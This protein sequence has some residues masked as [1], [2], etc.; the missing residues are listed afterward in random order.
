MNA[1]AETRPSQEPQPEF[2]SLQVRLARRFYLDLAPSGRKPLVVVC[3]GCEHC[4]A[5]YAVR[6]ASFP[7]FS[8]E[9]VASGKGLLDLAGQRVELLPGMVFS[10]GP[11]IPHEITSDRTDPP[12]K[13]FIDFAGTQAAPLLRKYAFAPGTITRVPPGE[14]QTIFDDLI[15]NGLKATPLTPL[16]CQTLLKYLVLKIG[17]LMMPLETS[18]ARAFATFQ[19]CRGYIQSRYASLSTLGQIARECHVD[20]AYLCRLFRRFDHQT[21]YQLLLRLKMNFAAQRL[22]DPGSL[23]K[24]VA[25]E[26]GFSDPFHFSRAF[27]NVFGLSPEAF[28]RL[29]G[30]PA[31]TT[32]TRYGA[33]GPRD[34][35][36]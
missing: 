14:I 8:I 9:F 18:Q 20:P 21:P 7:Y 1:D 35:R 5:D 23:V 32:R 36:R 17:E 15:Q 26:L 25:V 34:R 4:T 6:R 22:Q 29:R 12:V 33:N 13:Y 11:G 24:Q 19:R 27:K 31:I 16:L 2:F 10:Y 30:K 3:G 28:R